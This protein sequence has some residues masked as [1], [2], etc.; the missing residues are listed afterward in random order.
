MREGNRYGYIDRSGKFV[1][2]PQFSR[3]QEFSEGL[4]WVTTSDEGGGVNRIGWID[5]AGRWIVTSV[6]G[7][8]LSPDLHEFFDYANPHQ[9][10][11]YTNGLV[12][13]LFFSRH[14]VFRGYMDRRGRTV[15][16]PIELEDADP[17]VGGLA[18]IR[19][20]GDSEWEENYGY[21]NKA[22]VIVW[23]SRN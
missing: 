10:W 19:F 23:R 7:R 15:I 21:I 17:F 12:S 22:G 6:G 14:R 1:L 3:A 4:A 11:R 13:F 5:K 18:W 8:K 2:E 20:P 9:D 16:R